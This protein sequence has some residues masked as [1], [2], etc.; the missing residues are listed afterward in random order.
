M[1]GLFDEVARTL[2]TPMPRGRAL[3]T[4]GAA[5]LAAA[6]PAFR[7]SSGLAARIQVGPKHCADYT[8]GPTCPK[9]CCRDCPPVP[10]GGNPGVLN[11]CCNEGDECDFEDPSEQYPC[12]RVRCKPQPP[13]VC[14]PDITAALEAALG[15]VKSTFAGW[16]G[17]RRFAA[18]TNLVTLPGA[19]VS[20]D[21]RELGPG[22]RGA[23]Q[24]RHAACSSC[25]YTV[26]VGSG[27]HY[28]GSVNYVVYGVMM[29]LCHDHFTSDDSSFADWYTREEMLEMIYMHKNKTGTQA[30]NFQASNEWALAGYQSG[31]VRPTP[32]AERPQC[33]PCPSG[34]SGSGLTV[35]WLPF[36]IGP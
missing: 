36:V 23:F 18:C 19:A 25:G 26:Q 24:T 30:G 33:K 22:G 15:R 10:S 35:N 28:S 8:E 21:V 6:V 14:G 2:A 32:P 29:R 17:A 27:C 4:L 7:P 31:R 9:R 13:K 34:Y 1:S 3:R 20:W 12:G 5:V 11:W 16:S